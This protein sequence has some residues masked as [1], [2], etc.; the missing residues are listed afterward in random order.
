MKKTLLIIRQTVA[1]IIAILIIVFVVTASWLKS[2]SPGSTPIYTNESGNTLA[3][4][5]AEV[6]HIKINGIEQFVL[7]RGKN[8]NNP[9]LL[10][11]HGGPGSPQ[12]HMNVKY[13]KELEDHYVVVNWDQRGAG[14]SYYDSINANNLNIDILVEDTKEVTNYLRS[15]F[16]KEKIFILG[17]SWGSYLGMRTIQ[18]YPEL[19]Y[20]YIGIGQVSDQLKSEEMSYR[21]VYQEAKKTNNTK[22]I[23]QLEEIGYPENGVY[24]NMTKA[25]RIERNWV[26]NFGGAAWGKKQRDLID[27]FI[28]P[29]FK[30]KEYRVKDKMN[31][32]KGLVKSQEVLW[33]GLID[34]QLVDEVKKVDVPVYILQGRHDY[35][36]CF[37]LAKSYFDSLQAPQKTFIEFSNSAHLLP[38]N[39]ETDKFHRI[40]NEQIPQEIL[41]QNQIIGEN[42]HL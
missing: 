30:F 6:N 17:H 26:T 13:N 27:M 20:A 4:S 3:N 25:M 11:L 31:Y 14:A 9:V 12:A 21:F 23:E 19:Y 34:H 32:M 5:I 39:N 40:L 24:P 15:R 1:W 37:D 22:A 10:M 18:K 33:A 2:V 28:L 7:I 29:L 8:I 38:Y 36:T 42:T 35:Q 41:N 16:N